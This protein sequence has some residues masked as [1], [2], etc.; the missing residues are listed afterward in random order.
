MAVMTTPAPPLPT[1]STLQL[2]FIGLVAVAAYFLYSYRDGRAIGTNPRPDL[3]PFRSTKQTLFLGD[4]LTLLK[5]KDRLLDNFL[6]RQREDGHLLKADPSR[7]FTITLPGMRMVLISKSEHIAHVQKNAFNNYRK[8]P[9]FKDVMQQV[10]G[11]Q[12]I[13]VADGHQW[14]I[15]RKATSKIFTAGNFKGII[16]SSIQEHIRQL[17][18]VIGDHA[19]KNEE[20]D[21]S[22]L[23]FRFTLD[24]FTEM[25]FGKSTRSLETCEPVPFAVAFDYAQGIMD[26]RFNNPFWHLTERFDGTKSKMEHAVRIMDDFAY[27]IIAQRE[28]EGRDGKNSAD[29]DLLSLYMAL[30]DE[31]GEPLSR[32]ALRD[33]LLNL[34]IAGR[35]TTAQGLSWTMF[36]LIRDPQ[37]FDL[38]RNEV[39]ELSDEIDYD[40]WRSMHATTAVFEEGLRLHPS[41]PK[42]AWECVVEGDVM[43]NGGPRIE[44][45]DR[46]SW[47]DWCRARDPEIWGPDAAEFKPSRFLDEKGHLIKPDEWK[48][49][50]FNGGRRLCLGMNLA[51]FEG[52]AVLAALARE[53]DFE[54]G[55]DYLATVPM[56]ENDNTPLYRPSLT[57][58]MAAPFMVRAQRRNAA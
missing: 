19:D 21:L 37:H 54:F 8:G 55:K 41:V 29:T 25:A 15:Q 10:L 1:L 56:C 27:G 11:E 50:V 52:S 9:L 28:I 6:Q 31:S 5:E 14:Q 44:K 43:P 2:V 4:F 36:R 16:T 24:S 32:Q 18:S 26:R 22:D 58:P 42:N 46:V 33:A 30:R 49:H 7:A 35:D 12:G 47:N 34:I 53:F 45:G 17:V 51:L 39:V 23:F 38:I 48:Y 3:V 57:L 13:F 20:F 40:T